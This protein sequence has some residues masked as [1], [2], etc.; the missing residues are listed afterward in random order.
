[1][2]E[3]Q[4]IP[5]LAD[6]SADAEMFQRQVVQRVQSGTLIACTVLIAS[7]SAPE[8]TITRLLPFMQPSVKGKENQPQFFAVACVTRDLILTLVSLNKRF[9]LGLD[10]ALDLLAMTHPMVHEALQAGSV[11][12]DPV[13]PGEEPKRVVR[14]V[15]EVGATGAGGS[16]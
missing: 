9:E 2:S 15:V 10:A 12:V 16:A 14:D 5:V 13:T 11:E 4:P 7:G 1:M 6:F 8:H 3:Q